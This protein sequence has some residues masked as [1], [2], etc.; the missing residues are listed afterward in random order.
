MTN[1][2]SRPLPSPSNW[3]DFE[4][5][6][7]DLFSRLWKT[8][9]AQMHGRVGQPQAGVDVYGADRVENVFAGVQCKGKDQG[10]ENPLT[11]SELRD[12]VQKAISFDPL[13]KVFILATTAPNDEAIQKLAR[14]ITKEHKQK[15]H[16]GITRITALR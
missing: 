14:D 9:D 4:R 16:Y 2:L 3:Q 13:L 10:F 1:V 8:N 7:F 12:E 11:A 5:L 15:G 6:C